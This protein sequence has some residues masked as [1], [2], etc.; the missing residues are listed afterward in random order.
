MFVEKEDG[1]LLLGAWSWLL[2]LLVV[3]IGVRIA[4][5][6]IAFIGDEM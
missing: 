1:M 3:F 5:R 2:L 4:L 6:V